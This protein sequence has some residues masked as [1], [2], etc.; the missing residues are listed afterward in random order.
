MIDLR[1]H[2]KKQKTE[3]DEPIG[4]LILYLMPV[5]TVFMILLERAL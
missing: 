3:E 2:P 4:L 5:M 1:Y